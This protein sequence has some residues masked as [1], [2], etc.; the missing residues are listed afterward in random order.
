VDADVDDDRCRPWG[1]ADG[2][3][4]AAACSGAGACLAGVACRGEAAGAG[5]AVG[6]PGMAAALSAAVPCA[7][8][9]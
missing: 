6:T 8:V 7:A 4:V 5:E 9:A 1:V 2:T 3:G